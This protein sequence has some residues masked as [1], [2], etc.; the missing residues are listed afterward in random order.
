MFKQKDSVVLFDL[1]WFL[2]LLLCLIKF[3]TVLE[4]HKSVAH[5]S[6]PKSIFGL[7][8]VLAFMSR[9]GKEIY[10]RGTDSS[11]HLFTRLFFFSFSFLYGCLS[12]TF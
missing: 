2:L 9:S 8:H 6:G 3:N 1:D 12:Q 4:E 10:L 11:L 5:S 7:L